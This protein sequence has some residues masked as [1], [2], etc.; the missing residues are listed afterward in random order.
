MKNNNCI[1][2]LE[3]LKINI[4][5]FKVP[6]QPLKEVKWCELW[7]KNKKESVY[8]GNIEIRIFQ[9]LLNVSGSQA[10]CARQPPVSR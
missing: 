9:L 8:D 7:T 4:E 2:L 6:I 3:N 1:Y 10:L 5:T